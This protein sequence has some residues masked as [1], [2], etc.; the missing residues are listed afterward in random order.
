LAVSLAKGR[1]STPPTPPTAAPNWPKPAPPLLLLLLLSTDAEATA[2][3][4]ASVLA[5]PADSFAVLDG[6]L[7]LLLLLRGGALAA[8]LALLPGLLPMLLLLLGESVV[9]LAI[10]L[11]PLRAGVA[12]GMLMMLACV[13]RSMRIS[14]SSGNNSNS[15]SS[16][17]IRS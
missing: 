7:G 3:G 11:L 16:I 15:D 12:L 9:M 5:A 10:R 2:A 13:M 4:L 1:S 6:E 8:W 17:D 14:W